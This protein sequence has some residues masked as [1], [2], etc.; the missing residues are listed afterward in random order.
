MWVQ[1]SQEQQDATGTDIASSSVEQ[2]N[3]KVHRADDQAQVDNDN[4]DEWMAQSAKERNQQLIGPTA[5]VHQ[6]A[7]S[8]AVMLIGKRWS[9]LSLVAA[10]SA[11]SCSD[12]SDSDG[13][14]VS[15]NIHIPAA[16]HK[17]PDQLLPWQ[18]R[19]LLTM[20]VLYDSD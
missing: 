5:T 16:I 14:S 12:G 4:D 1:E 10:Q 11:R 2:W 6:A 15:V 17:S 7:P 3:N 8:E 18:G 20:D 13:D 19:V 9:E